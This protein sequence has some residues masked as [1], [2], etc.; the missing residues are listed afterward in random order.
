LVK[1]GNRCNGRKNILPSING[2]GK[3]KQK[4][5]EVKNKTKIISF[6]ISLSHPSSMAVVSL[7]SLPL[8]ADTTRVCPGF[9]G[10]YTLSRPFTGRAVEFVAALISVSLPWS[11]APLPPAHQIWVGIWTLAADWVGTR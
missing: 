4:G 8:S 6:F 11:A 7:S 5:G 2:L 1:K 9:S 3:I 10:P